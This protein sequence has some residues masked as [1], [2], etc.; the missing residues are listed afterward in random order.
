MGTKTRS[1]EEWFVALAAFK[2]TYGH[3]NVPSNGTGEYTSFYSW[4]KRMHVFYKAQEGGHT[5]G[6][7]LSQDR[8]E[9]L[10]KLEF[11]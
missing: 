2:A 4:C 5:G 10:Q 11:E 3:C 6:R 7:V 9:T 1:F 8:I